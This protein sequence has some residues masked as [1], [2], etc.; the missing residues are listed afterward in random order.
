MAHRCGQTTESTT[1]WW[2]EDVRADPTTGLVSAVS[3][4]QDLGKVNKFFAD[5]LLSPVFTLASSPLNIPTQI[6]NQVP[7]ETAIQNNITKPIATLEGFP[8]G[9]ADLLRDIA[10]GTSGFAA[11]DATPLTTDP[12][13][14]PRKLTNP[15]I[16]DVPG[17][18]TN[19]TTNAGLGKTDPT[20]GSKSSITDVPGSLTAP[21]R[22]SASRLVNLGLNSTDRTDTGG[23]GRHRLE[24]IGHLASS[25]TP[26]TRKLNGQKDST[27]PGHTADA[28]SGSNPSDNDEK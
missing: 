14:G 24:N 3:P 22:K 1:L 23:G 8:A 27:T 18:I 12:T 15:S 11:A 19:A 4:L 26:S 5:N 10:G 20:L 16:T 13:P 2:P 9:L 7:P 25:W 17:I 28:T 21:Q 6:S